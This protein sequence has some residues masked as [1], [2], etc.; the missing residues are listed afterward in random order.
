MTRQRVG[1]V[2]GVSQSIGHLTLRLYIE[3]NLCQVFA[4]HS[5]GHR[6]SKESCISFEVGI[7]INIKF[8]FS[9]FLQ[10]SLFITSS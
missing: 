7:Y 9:L 2:R 5:I 10:V 8:L 6:P 3:I 1:Y 4:V